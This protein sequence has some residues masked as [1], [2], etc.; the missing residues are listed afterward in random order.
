MGTNL[1]ETDGSLGERSLAYYEARAR[2]G[3]GLLI[4]GSVAVS[5]PR[6]TTNP[7]QVA[8]S[9][10]AF[11]PGM[12]ELARRAHSH[13]AGVAVQLHHGGRNAVFDIAAGRPLFVPSAP[14]FPG[15]NDKGA[16]FTREEAAAIDAM[17][18]GA[19]PRAPAASQA[20]IDGLV[21]D[22]G[23]AAERAQRAG[24]DAIEVHAAHGY[25]IAGFLSPAWNFR[26]DAYG[27]SP[28]RRA[29]LLCEV[30]QGIRSRVGTNYPVWCRIDACEFRVEGGLGIEAARRNARFAQEAGADA[31]HVSA[32]SDGSSGIGFTEGP[33]VHAPCGYADFA[34]EIKRDVSIPVIAV[35]RIE[36]E[37]ADRL[38]ERGDADFVAMGRKLIADPELPS[39]LAGD[40]AS[41]IRPCIYCYR[42]VG[43]VC[44]GRAARCSVN[45]LAGHEHERR[46][47][48]AA[49]ARHVVV[50]GGGP[51]G[52][53]A[54]R[55]ASLRGH[56]V[57]L[58][59]RGAR[60]G[61][62]LAPSALFYPPNAGLI[63]WL[64]AELSRLDVDVKLD[65]E[66]RPEALGSLAPD[67]IVVA[68]GGQ[69]E[70]GDA[71]FQGTPI[72]VIDVS[73]LDDA[74]E[75]RRR[76][77]DPAGRRFVVMGGSLVG[78]E[79]A[80]WISGQ[81]GQPV[82]LEEGVE[83]ASQMAL[84]RRW[85][86]LHHLR[87]RGVPLLTAARRTGSSRE[88]VHYATAE[89]DFEVTSADTVILTLSGGEDARFA[90]SLRRVCGEVHVVGDAAGGSSIDE[91]I[92]AGFERGNAV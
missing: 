63:R 75:A 61:G 4:V 43:E 83:I 23:D 89:G 56:R 21:E 60:L 67:A 53:E 27:G 88:S 8:L 86:S 44:V 35:G 54:A 12:R 41:E 20:D 48:K 74:S 58:L 66:A 34:A 81:G 3:A 52:M 85:R 7:R 76:I 79:I 55:V 92:L 2:G 29:R 46:I 49:V 50:I 36:P 40:R 30:L 91:A 31:V 17:R 1:S 5:A 38:I 57:T 65:F 22:F 70:V 39:K 77:G 16:A 19:T 32:Y 90:Q 47:E 73:T 33:L 84:P 13:G 69:R 6:G 71:A 37:E 64:E 25:A 26:E 59:E 42:C 10:D 18:A 87:E 14:R 51:A 80:E 9:S 72:S 78:V 11:V 68:T 45:A 82:V 24:I 28:S 62:R 15:A